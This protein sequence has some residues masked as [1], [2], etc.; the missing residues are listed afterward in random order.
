MEAQILARRLAFLQFL[1]QTLEKWDEEQWR[2]QKPRFR[3][4]GKVDLYSL[5]DDQWLEQFR[6][7]QL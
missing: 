2:D 5:G 7:N 1:D 4:G 6:Y 3:P